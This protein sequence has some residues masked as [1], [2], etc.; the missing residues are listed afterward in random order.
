[1]KEDDTVDWID[2]N[3]RLP[4]LRVPVLAG[5]SDWSYAVVADYEGRGVWKDVWNQRFPKTD[6]PTHWMPMPEMPEERAG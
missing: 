6:M 4:D 3:D 5:C 2:V 1:M